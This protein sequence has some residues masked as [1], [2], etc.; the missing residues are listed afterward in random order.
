MQAI[1]SNMLSNFVDQESV[2]S[3]AAK[4]TANYVSL[5]TGVDIN[6]LPTIEEEANEF[7]DFSIQ[8]IKSTH[9]TCGCSSVADANEII[10]QSANDYDLSVSSFPSLVCSNSFSSNSPKKFNFSSGSHD[11]YRD[12]RCPDYNNTT[13][14]IDGGFAGSFGAE[15]KLQEHTCSVS[16]FDPVLGC[17]FEE[18][19]QNIFHPVSPTASLYRQLD[20]T[21]SAITESMS[22]MVA[23]FPLSSC[24]PESDCDSSVES[25]LSIDRETADD[26]ESSASATATPAID[27]NS[28]HKGRRQVWNHFTRWWHRKNTKCDEIVNEDSTFAN[29]NAN[30]E[31]KDKELTSDFATVKVDVEDDDHMQSIGCSSCDIFEQINCTSSNASSLALS[32]KYSSDNNGTLEDDDL[33]YSPSICSS[34]VAKYSDDDYSPLIASS[35]VV[36]HD[37]DDEE[38]LDFSNRLDMIGAGYSLDDV[39]TAAALE[40]DDLSYSPSIS[41]SLVAEQ[42]GDEE[43]LYFPNRVNMIDAHWQLNIACIPSNS[44]SQ[45]TD[46]CLFAGYRKPKKMLQLGSWSDLLND[47]ANLEL[48]MSDLTEIKIDENILKN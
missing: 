6:T 19:L 20:R 9:I 32:A 39:S 17:T 24:T 48:Y 44:I 11:D 26:L 28:S 3:H 13:I 47:E 35:L 1:S 31:V 21:P 4:E 16:T 34:L 33:S 23:L 25:C 29:A 41:S 10:S 12:P 8:S 14:D 42:D 5:S 2:E 7:S 15:C 30:V 40:D 37:A 43:T 22:S 18:A 45:I 38:T 27:C 46:S 36:E